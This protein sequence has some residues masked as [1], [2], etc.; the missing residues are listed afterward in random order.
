MYPELPLSQNVDKCPEG[1]KEQKEANMSNQN[2]VQEPV[3]HFDG[4]ADRSQLL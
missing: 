3:L 2:Y 4:K 1:K